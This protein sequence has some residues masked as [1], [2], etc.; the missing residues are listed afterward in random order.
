M[1]H[2]LASGVARGAQRADDRCLLRERVDCRDR[3]DKCQHRDDDVKEHHHGAL[4]AAHILTGEL[5]ALVLILRQNIGHL[6]HRE[7]CLARHGALHN[8]R[9]RRNQFFA[10]CRQNDLR[11]RLL[12]PV[13]LRPHPVPPRIADHHMVGVV[14]V[15]SFLRHD[16]DAERLRVEHQVR[17]VLKQRAVVGK[18]R[19]SRDGQLLPADR[20]RIADRNPGLRGV[21]R[22]ERDLSRRLRKTPLHHLRQVHLPGAIHAKRRLTEFLLEVIRAVHRRIGLLCYRR[23]KRFLRPDIEREVSVLHIVV[24]QI[25]LIRLR[26][27]VVGHQKARDDRH[28]HGDKEENDEVFAEVRPEFAGQPSVHR[29]LH[30]IAPLTT[31]S[32]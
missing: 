24:R 21:Q 32:R 17:I 6:K 12:V 7:P 10:Q 18:C 23:K 27:A 15:K 3:H 30:D 1:P 13:R 8:L 9:V 2:H 31:R 25:S 20:D 4:V 22:V 19:K 28:D 11:S 5:Y 14:R 26:N 16:A 29:I